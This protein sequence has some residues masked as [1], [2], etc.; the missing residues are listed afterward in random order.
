METSEKTRLYI[1]IAIIVCLFA[2]LIIVLFNSSKNNNQVY[3]SPSPVAE[4]SQDEFETEVPDQADGIPQTNPFDEDANPISDA[5]QNP[6][7]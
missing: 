5:Y 1:N 2:G 3:V 7:E 6:F 4:E